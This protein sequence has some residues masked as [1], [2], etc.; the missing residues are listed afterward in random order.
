ME[1]AGDGAV[2]FR[3]PGEVLEFLK[4]QDAVQNDA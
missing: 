4:P 1:I 2:V 3:N